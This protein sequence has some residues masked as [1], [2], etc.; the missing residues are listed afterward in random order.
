MERICDVTESMPVVAWQHNVVD[1]CPHKK[2]RIVKEATLD[3]APSYGI[4]CNK[5]N[6]KCNYKNCPCKTK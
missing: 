2:M 5:L 1:E 6:T 3:T 4:W